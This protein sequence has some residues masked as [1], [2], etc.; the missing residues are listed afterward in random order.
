MRKLLLT[1]LVLTGVALA[2]IGLGRGPEGVQVPTA[3]TLG[4]GF[5]FISASY[6]SVNDGR[7][8]AMNGFKFS[9]GTIQPTLDKNTPSSGGGVSIGYG[10]SDVLDVGLSLPL[11]YDGEIEGTD[12]DGFAAGDLQAHIK[13]SYP[14]ESFPI[15]LAL[16]TE[17]Y[18]PTGA[19]SV[20]FRPRHQWYISD[21]REGYAYT[22]AKWSILAG[23]LVSINVLD[24]LDWNFYIGYLRTLNTD[25]NT[26][27][28][29]SSFE[30]YPQKMVSGIV[31]VSA[32]T[33]MFEENLPQAIANNVFR[34]TPAVVIHLPNM[35][36]LTLGLNVG[37][38]FI[39]DATIDN[40][41]EVV[42]KYKDGYLTYN[43]RGTP[44]FSMVL[45]VS[46]TL[47]FSRKDTDNDGVFDRFDLCPS[48][49]LGVT[50]NTRGCPVDADV[51]GVLNIMDLCPET[52]HGVI[53]D[54]NGCP[55]DSDNDLVPDYLDQCPNSPLGT[56]VD[57]TGC[58]LDTDKDG[59]DDNHDKCPNTL[60]RDKVDEN[61]CPLD[62]DHDGVLNDIDQCPETP[63]GYSVDK[64][65][66]P[67]DF[68][69]DG[70]PND[71]DMC[72]N[73][74]EGEI[75]NEDGCPADNDKDGVPDSRDEC[76]DTPYGFSVYQNGC[77]TDHDNDEVPDDID[78]CPNTPAKAAVDTTGCPID[79]DNDG[80][81]DYQDQCPGT[82]AAV[83][84]DKAGCPLDPKNNLNAI[85]QMIRFKGNSA[86][87]LNSSYTALNDIIYLLRKYDFILL[88]Q[89]SH[90]D[91]ED[92]ALNQADAITQ[93]LVDKGISEKRINADGFKGT[94]PQ[95]PNNKH[96]NKSGVRLIPLKPLNSLI[97]K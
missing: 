11:Y 19:K 42:R 45:V 66:C 96:W 53:V 8:L 28:W 93:Y 91:D 94:L 12:L 64:S 10:I 74:P 58:M 24:V 30:I 25:R 22:A 81:F 13:Y 20:G 90:K 61:G 75:V 85:A 71:I 77:P 92:I 6:E 65:G 18:I 63:R 4:Q 17:L 37:V 51:D 54:Y 2:Q 79:S 76:I 27:L 95:G 83:L 35:L 70:I 62:D 50:V 59:V 57:S 69:H 72:P 9:D 29:G 80:V 44:E 26:I 73:S 32:E 56:A 1:L 16:L 68:D 40:S 38:D 14:I 15:T 52:P 5:F 21:E 67:L 41:Q 86:E 97:K 33:G 89:C 39:R 78:K 60:S 34:V 88:I 55:L 82:F 87:F 46:K 43:I 47:D 31:E 23:G 7:P 48:T 84:V 49:E 36:N 3:N